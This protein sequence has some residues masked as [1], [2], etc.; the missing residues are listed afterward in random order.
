MTL[1]L[2]AVSLNW[3]LVQ[4]DINNAFLFLHGE[5]FE[6]VYIGLPFGCTPQEHG[7]VSFYV[8]YIISLSMI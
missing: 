4:L 1:L 8:D 5:S 2:T 7:G 3:P 6:E